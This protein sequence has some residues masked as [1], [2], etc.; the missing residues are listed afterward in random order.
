MDGADEDLEPGTLLGEGRYRIESKLGEGGFGAVYEATTVALD[1]PVAIKVLNARMVRE[2]VH[3]LRFKREALVAAKLQSPHVV[4]MLDVDVG[5]GAGKPAFLVMERL[6]GRPLSDVIRHEGPFSAERTARLG[7]QMLTGLAEAHSRGVVHRDVKPANL[8][9]TT[10]Y[11][12]GEV[13]K[14]LDFGVA[15]LV[16]QDGAPPLTVTGQVLGTL[17][18]MA[19]E[20]AAG[21]RVDGRADVY[22]VGTVLWAALVGKPPFAGRNRGTLLKRILAGEYERLSTLRPELGALAAVVDRAMSLRPDER[23]SAE[24]MASELLRWGVESP[25]GND[26]LGDFTT[27]HVDAPQ[28]R[29]ARA[30]KP[31]G[32]WTR[33]VIVFAL[34]AAVGSFVL[35]FAWGGLSS[36]E[37]NGDAG[38]E[39]AVDPV[40]P[41]RAIEPVPAVEPVELDAAEAA[42]TFDEV[43]GAGP[44]TTSAEGPVATAERRFPPCDAYLTFDTYGRERFPRAADLTQGL[45]SLLRY[46]ENCITEA[47]PGGFILHVRADRPG[48]LRQVAVSSRGRFSRSTARCIER[49]ARQLAVGSP[50]YGYGRMPLPVNLSCQGGA[51]QVTPW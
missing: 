7:A 33:G 51:D 5:D 30:T 31:E 19:P 18:Y 11:D 13:L 15:R 17:N 34:L 6:E 22:A 10:G 16:E 21:T 39:H 35:V 38:V 47:E 24:E 42:V 4:R 27:T 43:E 41:V 9:I 48:P 2:P 29:D 8:F 25:G 45:N 49:S 23:P 40:E 37:T 20:Q 3:V 12:G 44:D 1:S 32:A 26:I 28:K 50:L 36:G 46:S 14:V